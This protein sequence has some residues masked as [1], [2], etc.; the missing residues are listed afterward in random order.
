MISGAPLWLLAL[1]ALATFFL[2]LAVFYVSWRQWRTAHERAILDVFDR[3]FAL[4][5][6]LKRALLKAVLDARGVTRLDAFA[7]VDQ[8]TMLFGDDVARVVH[9]SLALVDE[10][11]ML[12]ARLARGD[13]AIGAPGE[14]TLL[15]GVWQCFRD[16][17]RTFLP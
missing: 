17:D 16:V 8:Y 9:R 13:A 7:N 5:E 1:Q 11:A 6:Q 15:E 12:Q 14:E 3:R 2:G 4:Y 10:L